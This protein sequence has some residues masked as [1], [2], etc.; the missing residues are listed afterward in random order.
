[1]NSQSVQKLRDILQHRYGKGLEVSILNDATSAEIQSAASVLK[2]GDLRIPISY[3]ERF[4]ATAV[5]KNA[6]DLDTEQQV[7]VAHLVRMVL[8]PAFYNWFLNQAS[9]TQ[10][11]Q[12]R[13]MQNSHHGGF[14]VDTNPETSK[15]SASSEMGSGDSS[16]GV[17]SAS[18]SYSNVTSISGFN[19]FSESRPIVQLTDRI[20]TLESS[21]DE[22]INKVAV[23]FHEISEKWAMLRFAELEKQLHTV[24]DL[25]ELGDI[26]LLIEDWSMM[27]KGHKQILAEYAQIKFE[28]G[29][30]LILIGVKSSVSDV[31]SHGEI[32]PELAKQMRSNRIELG[33]LPQDFSRLQ[34]SLKLLLLPAIEV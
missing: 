1:M 10:I 17:H 15:K 23:H 31:L 29:S 16:D 34:E 25:V 32:D 28:E 22:L 2:A 33:R 7:T 26:T 21:R 13:G 19:F 4:L 9:A 12:A 6:E 24:N 18:D 8:E 20:W 3:N 11:N 30:P 14:Y 27:T 5:V